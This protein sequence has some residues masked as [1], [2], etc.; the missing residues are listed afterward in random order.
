MSKYESW[1]GFDLDGTL[2]RYEGWR[3]INHIG[4]PIDIMVQRLKYEQSLGLRVKIFTARVAN[5]DNREEAIKVIEEWCMKHLGEVLE[6]T[7]I[8][9]MGMLHLYDDRSIQVISNTGIM[10][11]DVAKYLTSTVE[12]LEKKVAKLENKKK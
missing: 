8:K 7:C 1:V 12:R 11:D 4:E 5:E 9:D 10:V 2:A 6:I 3:G